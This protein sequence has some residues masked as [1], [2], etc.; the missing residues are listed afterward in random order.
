M[1]H[2][3]TLQWALYT[4]P[5]LIT[6]ACYFIIPA[7]MWWLH[8]ARV[9]NT[10]EGVKLTPLSETELFLFRVF[11]LACGLHHL[12]HP[13]FMKEN[14]FG[15]LIAVDMFVAGVSGL[16]AYRTTKLVYLTHRDRR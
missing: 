14:L 13:Y 15:P 11:I 4:I 5:N 3:T 6:A 9:T 8:K 16:T 12:V 10:G 1:D 7:G 2:W